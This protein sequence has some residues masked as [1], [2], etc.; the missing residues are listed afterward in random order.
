MKT[1]VLILFL[2][3]LYG[4]CQAQE[5]MVEV[6]IGTFV[7]EKLPDGK[8]LINCPRGA[9]VKVT[10]KKG[11]KY[12]I[13]SYR[14]VK[15][16]MYLDAFSAEDKSHI[17]QKFSAGNYNSANNNSYTT[18][19]EP[20]SSF[21]RFGYVKIRGSIRSFPLPSSRIITHI[22]KGEK[23]EITGEN[24]NSEYFKVRFLST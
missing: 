12:V 23:I 17:N 18:F 5:L 7:F 8:S 10:D 22:A 19:S 14:G 1:S 2:G 11:S 24:Q 6:Q 21:S 3:F 4:I 13:A 20:Q 9:V 15:G 16:Y